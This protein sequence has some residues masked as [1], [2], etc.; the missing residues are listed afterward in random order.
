MATNLQDLITQARSAEVTPLTFE[1]MSLLVDEDHFPVLAFHEPNFEPTVECYTCQ[2]TDTWPCTVTRLIVTSIF[3]NQGK[4]KMNTSYPPDG[5]SSVLD[6]TRTPEERIF[7]AIFHS[8]PDAQAFINEIEEIVEDFNEEDLPTD[9]KFSEADRYDRVLNALDHLL[10]EHNREEKY[11]AELAAIFND[12]S[13][14]YIKKKAAIS[15]FEVVRQVYRNEDT[16]KEY[17]NDDDD[18]SDYDM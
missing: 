9:S 10:A 3:I 2:H 18:L 12:L 1:N 8:Q 13:Q 17:S 6:D 4:L 11:A 16:W 7:D 15:Q 5:I 14:G